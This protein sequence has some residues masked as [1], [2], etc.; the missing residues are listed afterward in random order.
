M[1]LNY[2]FVSDIEATIRSVENEYRRNQGL[3][4]T[5]SDLAALVYARLRSLFLKPVNRSGD[6]WTAPEAVAITEELESHVFSGDFQRL[7]FLRNIECSVVELRI[8]SHI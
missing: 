2:E 6:E 5:E 4:L 3:I 8:S 1:A 7:F